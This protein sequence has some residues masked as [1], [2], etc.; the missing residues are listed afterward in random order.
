MKDNITNEWLDE[1]RRRIQE[2]LSQAKKDKLRTEYGMEFEYTHPGLSP[3]VEN[4]WLDYVLEFERQFEQAKPITVRERIGNPPLQPLSD[5]PLEAVSEA[6]T[7]LLDLLAAHGIAVDFLGDVDELEAYRYL[8][9]E[10]LDEEMDDIRIEGMMTHFT[11]STPEYDVQMWV[12]SFVL[13][14][15]THE[16]EYFLP[17][18]AKQP[19]FNTKGE[20]I[21]PIQF[22]QTIEAVWERLPP[23]NKV[24]VKPIVTQV[25]EDEAK[26]WATISWNDGVQQLKGQVESYFHL[27]PSPYTG[28]DVVQT[29]LLDDLLA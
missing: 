18:L 4:E 13:D 10:L 20:P 26:V 27:Q 17:G 8:T 25:E 3:E 29:S 28:W 7:V 14:L 12:E 24:E 22:Q 11:Y 23:T 16:K 21:T 6:V 2:A 1:I 15:F 9:E 5:L 19:L